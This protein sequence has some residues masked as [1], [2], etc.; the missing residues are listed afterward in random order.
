M[1]LEIYKSVVSGVYADRVVTEK[2]PLKSEKEVQEVVRRATASID[3]LRYRV[4]GKKA[5]I[6]KITKS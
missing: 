3:P 1:H 5:V 2:H 4:I 6:P